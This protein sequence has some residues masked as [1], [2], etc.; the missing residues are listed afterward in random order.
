MGSKVRAAGLLVY[1]IVA[2]KKFEYLL[3]QA[4]YP[5]HHWTP[6]K[7]H[8]DPGE[9]EWQAA[10]RETQEEAHIEQSQLEIDKNFKYEMFYEANGKPKSVFYWLAKLKNNDAVHL[11]HEHQNWKWAPLD[12][13]ITTTKF[14]EMEKMLRQAEEYLLK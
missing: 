11:S 4:S 6:P 1:R 9:D 5:P 7:G 3:L 2:E 13:A 8:V 12:D 14:P 10:L